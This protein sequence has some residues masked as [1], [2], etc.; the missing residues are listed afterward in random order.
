[1]CDIIR[2]RNPDN[3][4]V[5]ID[6]MTHA[7]KEVTQFA[8]DAKAS[9]ETCERQNK[10]RKEACEKAQTTA[11]QMYAKPRAERLK[12]LYPNVPASI[13]YSQSVDVV[14]NLAETLDTNP[15]KST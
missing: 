5:I 6:A 7:M 11:Y 12:K 9:K 1:M 3:F 8:P 13:I 15:Q 10:R 4:D 14:K 2:E